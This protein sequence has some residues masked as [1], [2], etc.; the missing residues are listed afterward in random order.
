MII[1]PHQLKRNK[2][3]E[4][5]VQNQSSDNSYIVFILIE[6]FVII[7]YFSFYLILFI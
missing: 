5:M 1:V 6:V 7:L 3:L 2:I 4:K